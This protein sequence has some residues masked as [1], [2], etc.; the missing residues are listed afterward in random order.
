LENLKHSSQIATEL[1]NKNILCKVKLVI[2][3]LGCSGGPDRI[4]VDLNNL[5]DFIDYHGYDFND[6]EIRRLIKEYPSNFKFHSKKI[7][8][9][10][11]IEADQRWWANSSAGQASSEA[12]ILEY[13]GS[14]IQ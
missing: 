10:R 1:V 12:D 9:E 14:E 4:L 5:E 7:V 3:D 11:S 6:D 13:T 8:A 2:L